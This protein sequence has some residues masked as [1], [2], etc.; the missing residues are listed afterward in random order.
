M[1]YNGVHHRVKV[2][3]GREGHEAF[4]RQ[5]RQLLGCSLETVSLV[6]RC[7]TPDTGACNHQIAGQSVQVSNAASAGQSCTWGGILFI[8]SPSDVRIRS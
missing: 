6:F 1:N 2:R 3:P 7:H 5:L 4:L 8:P